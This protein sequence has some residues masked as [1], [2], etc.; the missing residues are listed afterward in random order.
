MRTKNDTRRQAIIETASRLFLENGFERTSMS[1]I[2]SQLGGSKGTLYN[3]FNCKEDLFG[4]VIAQ[5]ADVYMNDILPPSIECENVEQ[6]LRA[7]GEKFLKKVCSQE[8]V[9]VNRNVY[10]EAGMSNIGRVFYERA[11]LKMLNR[12][13]TV[14]DHWM[15]EG[16]L[17]RADP[18][19]AAQQLAALLDA[20][21]RLVVLLG[22]QS[23]SDPVDVAPI[24]ARGLDA[25]LRI[26][27]PP[28]SSPF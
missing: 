18:F 28:E 13:A 1:E 26:Y 11:P 16:Q 8:F 5:L 4:E 17:R 3:Y 27:T 2:A 23:P 22:V 9:T 6:A 19:V 25:F 15:T 21:V 20:E 7:F 12:L 10:A 24:A 14:L